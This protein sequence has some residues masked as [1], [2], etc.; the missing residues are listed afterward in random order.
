MWLLVVEDDSGVGRALLRHLS[1][2]TRL[3]CRLAQDLRELA[4]ILERAASPPIAAVLDF[5]LGGGAGEGDG[6]S[7]LST[8]R[9]RG[10]TMPCAFYSG[11]PAPEIRARL[12]AS[13][14]RETVPCFEKLDAT[15]DLVEW[16]RERAAA[17][18]P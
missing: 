14:S 2:G 5:D 8:I 9:A 11:T 15:G 13:G 12:L 1:A 6:V 18:A 17:A 3:E 7:A 4:L 10:W 16:V